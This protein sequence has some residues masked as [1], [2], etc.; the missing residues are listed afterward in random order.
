[1]KVAGKNIEYFL[2]IEGVRIPLRSFA[3]ENGTNRGASLSFDL[4]PLATALKFLRGMQVHLF[5][6]E[7]TAEPVMRFN[8]II[9][10]VSYSKHRNSRSVKIE[11]GAPDARWDHIAFAEFDN[12]NIC[13]SPNVTVITATMT[14]NERAEAL[15]AKAEAMGTGSGDGVTVMQANTMVPV[16][17]P[18]TGVIGTT[19]SSLHYKNS[20]E[21]NNPYEKYLKKDPDKFYESLGTDYSLLKYRVEEGKD[22]IPTVAVKSIQ[23][24]ETNMSV[25]TSISDVFMRKI[26]S[27]G[28]DILKGLIEIIKMGYLNGNPYNVLEYD[29]VKLARRLKSMNV[30][31]GFGTGI[32]KI[33]PPGT[34][35]TMASSYITDAI[36]LLMRDILGDSSGATPLREIVVGML[37][38]LLSTVSVDTNNV[39]NSIL[40]HPIMMSFLPPKCNVIFPGQYSDIVY[41]P[42]L[43][44]KPTRSIIAFPTTLGD[45]R[46]SGIIG[47]DA[48]TSGQRAYL[49]DS[50]DPYLSQI[51]PLSAGKTAAAVVTA[52]GVDI[53]TSSYSNA[54]KD[55][56]ALAK[57]ITDEESR[58]GVLT[59]YQNIQNPVF[60]RMD[61]SSAYMLANFIHYMSK[62]G[63]RGCTVIGELLDDL[64][65]GMPIL[66]LDGEFS[67]YG[68]LQGYTYSVDEQGQIMS[69]LAISCPQ[70]VFEEILPKPPLWL[71]LDSM[72]PS[73]IGNTYRELL[74]C[75]SIYDESVCGTENLG[76]TEILRRCTL[77]L[78]NSY[79]NS[80]NTVAFRDQYRKRN[81]S[82]EK[83]IFSSVHDCHA[84]RASGKDNSVVMWQGTDFNPYQLNPG[85]STQLPPV[86][87]QA[88]VLEFLKDYYG[89]PG[90]VE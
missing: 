33:D 27:S 12:R 8:G 40:L 50:L 44:N 5:K 49:C 51:A 60:S 66:I 78:L 83:Y 85:Q 30:T 9:K 67:I 57:I 22:I 43:W 39:D 80:P 58:E 79:Y 7:G 61:S 64:A 11:V 45:G 31:T 46:N 54:A 28:G 47:V 77:E 41:N 20:L 15:K 84:V 52:D 74:G 10:N 55:F 86:D 87:K 21:Y 17:Q 25:A 37:N 88:I 63:I 16:D 23:P 3:V 59:N 68:I 24:V 90:R 32:F 71:D 19:H 38:G 2:Y 76:P 89:K 36:S 81:N 72:S 70:F 42:N 18:H 13:S 29:R 65:V 34:E 26:Y 1:M 4:L 53:S 62:L 69:D 82:T 35:S 6:K 75:D 73:K 14:E 56:M 48:K